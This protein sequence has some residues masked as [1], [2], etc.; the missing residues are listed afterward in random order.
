MKRRQLIRHL[1]T[2]ALFERLGGLTQAWAA[3][4]KPPPPGLHE[5][6]GQVSV[7]GQPA[8]HGMALGA[9][10]RIV[11]G[12]G[13]KAIY[14]VGSDAYLQ[15]SESSVEIGR[16]NAGRRVLRIL[17]GK[18]MGV[19]GK[20]EKTLETPVAT[21]GIRGTACYIEATPKRVYFCLCYGKA[22]IRAAGQTEIHT[23][24]E[25]HYH[26]HPIYLNGSGGSMIEPARVINHSD[27]ELML[28]ESLVGRL[29]PFVGM[30][31]SA[32]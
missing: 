7:N 24:L 29:P 22:D 30:G 2:L 15:R 25:T 6:S 16:D 4:Q 20:G 19:F 13:A 5:F 18:L 21:I 31:Y 27:A 12:A 1:A 10:D 8:K 9:G 23:T 32:Y 3:G 17:Q 26:D 11:T 14:I 28:L